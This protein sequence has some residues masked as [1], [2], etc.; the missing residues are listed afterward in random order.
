M[1]RSPQITEE[2]LGARLHGKFIPPFGSQGGEESRT[3]VSAVL[4]VV[5]K[6]QPAFRLADLLSPMHSHREKMKIKK[7]YKIS[8]LTETDDYSNNTMAKY[9]VLS[10][11]LSSWEWCVTT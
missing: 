2:K 4:G 5:G 8:F 1:K 9:I 6:V 10:L 3:C 11:Y 7:R